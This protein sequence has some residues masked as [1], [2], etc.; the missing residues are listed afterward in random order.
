[1]KFVEL[2]DA[3]LLD[4]YYGLDDTSDRCRMTMLCRFTQSILPPVKKTD[5]IEQ[6]LQ[7][8]AKGTTTSSVIFGNITFVELHFSPTKYYTVSRNDYGES[9]ISLVEE[10]RNFV[11][12]TN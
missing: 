9:N 12:V 4:V 7:H 2:P 10:K 6:L 5:R 11:T 8:R 1:M 3:V